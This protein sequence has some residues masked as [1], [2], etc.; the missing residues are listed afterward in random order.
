LIAYATWDHIG[1]RKVTMSN[2]VITQI[3]DVEL[4]LHLPEQGSVNGPLR[5]AKGKNG[6]VILIACIYDEIVSTSIL[7]DNPQATRIYRKTREE[8]SD[9]ASVVTTTDTSGKPIVLTSIHSDI[10]DETRLD[11]TIPALHNLS[12][13]KSLWQIGVLDR[14]YI[15]AATNELHG[16]AGSNIWGLDISPLGNLVAVVQTC[17]PTDSPSY[18]I[19][20][21]VEASI[22]ITPTLERSL[23]MFSFPHSFDITGPSGT[24]HYPSY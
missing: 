9:I 21:K 4:L 20:S 11:Y 23:E 10:Q 12:R 1:F 24:L 13:K 3:D 16:A 2:G 6:Y 15:F 7:I 18:I 8:W 22:S 19:P 17:H 5:F 14:Q